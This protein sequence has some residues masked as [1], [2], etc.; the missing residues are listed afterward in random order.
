MSLPPLPPATQLVKRLNRTS[1]SALHNSETVKQRQFLLPMSAQIH[2][3]ENSQC[4]VSYKN[5]LASLPNLMGFLPPPVST[6][7]TFRRQTRLKTES[8]C[9][10][11]SGQCVPVG[12]FLRPWR[13]QA[14]LWGQRG[15]PNGH[16]NNQF[17]NTSGLGKHRQW[18]GLFTVRRED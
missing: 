11:H 14:I 10:F 7:E 3:R 13:R 6:M 1:Y 15:Q 12:A 4:S 5:R 2:P 9:Q 16:R 8:L 18:K 17:H